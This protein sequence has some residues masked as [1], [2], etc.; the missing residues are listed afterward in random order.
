MKQNYE[1]IGS[2]EKAPL[3]TSYL[4]SWFYISYFAGCTAINVVSKICHRSFLCFL[5]HF[6]RCK[7]YSCFMAVF[8][9]LYP[10][11]PPLVDKLW[12][13]K[14]YLLYSYD[15]L[16]SIYKHWSTIILHA[17]FHDA[18]RWRRSPDQSHSL[19]YSLGLVCRLHSCLRALL[20]SC[21]KKIA[22]PSFHL[23]LLGAA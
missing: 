16:F 21:C 2:L 6:D 14:R 7:V 15:L 23:S 10:F 1:N 22:F 13:K 5:S 12:H 8:A 18:R 11:W 19:F 9:L 20:P 4:L 17:Q 3:C